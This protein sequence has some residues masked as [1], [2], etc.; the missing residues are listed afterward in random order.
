MMGGGR[1]SDSAAAAAATSTILQRQLLMSFVIEAYRRRLILSRN[2]PK[3]KQSRDVQHAAITNI[4][5]FNLCNHTD[6][7]DV[8]HENR[9]T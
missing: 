3:S 9:A 5:T 1:V 8:Q 7:T 4:P 6:L 2:K